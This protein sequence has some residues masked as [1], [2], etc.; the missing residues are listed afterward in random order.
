M[1]RKLKFVWI[2]LLVSSNTY[3]QSKGINDSIVNALKVAITDFFINEGVLDSNVNTSYV[4]GMDLVHHREIG[5]S[6][7]G[8]YRIGVFQSHGTEHVLIKYENSFEIFNLKDLKLIFE[9]VQQF[10]VKF[11]LD[12]QLMVLYFKEIIKLYELTF[13][14]LN[15]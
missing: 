9:K 8:I 5:K 7:F 12:D 11:K 1:I 10:S 6:N 14:D 2:I 13:Q 3:G 15:E 4:Y